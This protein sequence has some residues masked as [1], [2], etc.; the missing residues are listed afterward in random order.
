MS[1]ATQRQT[2]ATQPFV[3]KVCHRLRSAVSSFFFVH[4]AQES[5]DQLVEVVRRD[6]VVAAWFIELSSF[7][8]IIG[9]L[10]A[11]SACGFFL[12]QYWGRCSSCGRPLRW[13]LV[14][15]VVLQMSQI[16]VRAVL[17]ASIRKTSRAWTIEAC[18]VALTASPAWR[19]SK[20]VSLGLYGWFVLGVVWWMHSSDC[21]D[22][23][24]IS[25]LIA[26]VLLLSAARTALTL[27]ASREL[28]AP[29]AQAIQA[30]PPVVEGATRCQIRV[31]PCVRVGAASEACQDCS[32]NSK[33]PAFST[34]FAGEKCAV[35]LSDFEEGEWTQRLP[36]AHHFHPQC[37]DRW[38][39]LNKR[40]PL[41]MH[42]IDKV[43]TLPRPKGLKSQ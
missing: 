40:C 28:F 9:S 27:M 15:Q 35:C 16:P 24:G 12:T 17:L 23:P 38:L 29:T 36:C 10:A 8:S 25:M 42:P 20:V 4:D 43:C 21:E 2:Q 37:I 26:S 5:G 22:C 7:F 3:S 13:W 31:L 11:A 19:I 34:C 30:P 33:Q 18:M 32:D 1:V 39:L 14:G 41:C 6:P